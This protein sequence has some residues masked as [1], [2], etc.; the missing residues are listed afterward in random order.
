FEEKIDEALEYTK[1]IITGKLNLQKVTH[2][3][4]VPDKDLEMVREDEREAT[5]DG[6]GGRRHGTSTGGNPASSRETRSRTPSPSSSSRKEPRR[7]RP[8]T[9]SPDISGKSRGTRSQSPSP[10]CSRRT[11]RSRSSSPAAYKQQAPVNN[12]SGNDQNIHHGNGD[13]FTHARRSRA[14]HIGASAK[15]GHVDSATAMARAKHKVLGGPPGSTPFG[16]EASVPSV[17]PTPEKLLRNEDGTPK[18]E[19]G[20]DLW[21]K[22][23]SC[24]YPSQFSASATVNKEW[25]VRIWHLPLWQEICEKAGLALPGSDLEKYGYKK[26]TYY[27]LAHEN[28]DAIC[29]QCFQ[30]TRPSGSFGALPVRLVEAHVPTTIRICRDCRVDYYLEHSEPIPDN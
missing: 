9:P 25:Q 23:Y 10:S 28:S 2:N 13:S 8:R 15:V 26:P 18:Y 5:V 30:S 16:G 7:N 1:V 27:R 3:L 17:S 29:E 11:T 21:D 24:F 4:S 14:G 12:T 6:G 19:L 20:S 22:V